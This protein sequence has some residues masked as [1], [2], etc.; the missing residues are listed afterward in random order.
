MY[1]HRL[2]LSRQQTC[3]VQ[4][5]IKTFIIII[6]HDGLFFLCIYRQKNGKILLSVVAVVRAEEKEKIHN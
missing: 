6:K 5:D 1:H 4:I 3:L 2:A